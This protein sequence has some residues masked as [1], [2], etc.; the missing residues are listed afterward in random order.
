MKVILA[1]DS[2]STR[3]IMRAALERFGHE[4]IVAADG[5]SAWEAFERERA[6][7]V[8]LDWSMPVVDGLEVCRRIRASAASA[9]TFVL[10]ITSHDAEGDLASAL[11]AGV[12]DYAMKPITPAQLG[13]RV[14]IAQ[15]RLEI[16]AA[17]RRAE[18]ALARARWLAGIGETAI[19]VQHEVNNPLA[20]AI[21]HVGL[22]EE[23][24]CSPELREHLDTVAQQ[25]RRVAAVVRRLSTIQ[26]PR[27]VEYIAGS[28]MLD[29]SSDSKPS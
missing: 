18:E 4:V 26:E 8:I 16:A 6:P 15:R 10:M 7:L 21:M 3:H 28:R 2:T 11:D 20:A 17:R 27:S 29:L 5:Q 12:D 24:P 23:L 14:I 22:A 1:E 13:A 25:V 19:A 9:D